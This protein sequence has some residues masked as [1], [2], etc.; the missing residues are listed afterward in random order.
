[1]P[2]SPVVHLFY[3][4][5]TFT[6]SIL[7]DGPECEEKRD[8]V[9]G[10]EEASL[11]PPGDGEGKDEEGQGGALGGGQA[12]PKLGEGAGNGRRAG[13]LGGFSVG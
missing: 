6:P 3:K 2:L 12:A 8:T 10:G 4:Q 7:D 1:M 9:G 13:H 11:Q 5:F